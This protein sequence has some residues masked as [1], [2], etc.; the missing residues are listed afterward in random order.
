MSDQFTALV[1]EQ[2]RAI[3]ADLAAIR[4]E[5]GKLKGLQDDMVRLLGAPAQELHG[6]LRGSVIIP[7]DADLTEP[8]LDELWII[9]EGKRRD[10]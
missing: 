10:K 2:L 9:E 6:F 3:R 7:D 8:A 1:L 5:M 4:E